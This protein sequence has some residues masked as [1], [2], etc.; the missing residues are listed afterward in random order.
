M[1]YGPQASSSIATCAPAIQQLLALPVTL[2]AGWEDP[3]SITTIHPHRA[4]SLRIRTSRSPH[5]VVSI[6]GAPPCGIGCAL[7]V[8]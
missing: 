3:P 8:C 4:H 7:N 5:Q 2:Q 1:P 6:N